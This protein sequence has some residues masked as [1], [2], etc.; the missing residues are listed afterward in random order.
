[1]SITEIKRECETLLKSSAFVHNVSRALLVAVE[2]L[3]A[4]GHDTRHLASCCCTMC[5]NRRG[6]AKTLEEIE[7]C[8]Q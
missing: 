2:R 5:E 4:T 6:A 8:F 1:M 7:A 3:E